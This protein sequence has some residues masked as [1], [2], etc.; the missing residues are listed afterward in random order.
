[1]N[2]NFMGL[3]AA[4]TAFTAVPAQAVVVPDGTL[5]AVGTFNPTVNLTTNPSTYSALNGGTFQT[6]GTGGFFGATG[7][8]GVMNG[9]LQFSNVVGTTILQ[10]L[11]NF[12][13]FGDGSGGTFNYSVNSVTTNAL[14]NQGVAAQSGTLFLLG[15][16]VNSTL[17]Y[18]TPT[19]SSLTVQFNS[20]G[21]SPFSTSATLAVPPAGVGAVP[22]PAT[23]GLMLLGF[24]MIGV[25]LRSRR[26]T[27]VT[28]A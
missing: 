25:G 26:R 15:T 28:Y 9:T 18:D 3:L 5:A 4:A 16:I 21:G 19:A 24:G 10:T 13:V 2:K 20:T 27:T 11:S 22:E 6:T 7:G 14:V 8:T 1:M 17:G 12:F 23:W